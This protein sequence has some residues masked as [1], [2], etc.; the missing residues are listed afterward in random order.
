M[1][2]PFAPWKLEWT[3][4]HV[5]R[6][7]NWWSSHP[8]ASEQY[9]SRLYGDSILDDVE[10]RIP[11]SGVVMD[12]GAGPG[13][14]TEKLLRRGARVFSV[15]FSPESA[16]SLEARLSGRAG[17]LGA[18]TASLDR[19][20]CDDASAD[21]AILVEVV[22]HL[23]DRVLTPA[24]REVT[25]VLRPGGHLVLTTPNQEDLGTAEVLCPECGCVYH[26]VQHVRAWSAR[27]LT[28]AV[29][30]CGYETI[31]AQPTKFLRKGGWLSRTR[32]RLREMRMRPAPHLFYLARKRA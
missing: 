19:I 13:Y 1:T 18:R 12:F 17:F 30:P 10:R 6:F 4:A 25:R 11:L 7:W 2:K 8:Q 31:A 22:E 15:D 23:D 16:A 3:P 21:L 5:E 26:R 24:L 32:R 20:P 28:A 29:E 27:T 14:L 9:F